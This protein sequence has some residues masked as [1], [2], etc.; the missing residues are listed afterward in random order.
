LRNKL[1]LLLARCSI[2]LR[3]RTNVTK[4]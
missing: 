1:P 3:R 4:Y 2:L